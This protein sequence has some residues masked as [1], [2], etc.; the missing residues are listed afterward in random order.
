MPKMV[1]F[2]AANEPNAIYVC[3]YICCK[4]KSWSNVCPFKVKKLVHFLFFC[5]LFLKSHFPCRKKRIYDNNKQNNK[6]TISNVKNW[7][8]YVAQHTWTSF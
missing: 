1:K 7:S 8:N 5:F 4:V 3:I 6:N 2:A